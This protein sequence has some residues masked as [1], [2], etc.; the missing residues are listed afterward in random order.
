M[1]NISFLLAT[2]NCSI[3]N[4][5][6]HFSNQDLVNLFYKKDNFSNLEKYAIKVIKTEALAIEID[7]FILENNIPPSIVNNILEKKF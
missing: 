1:P 6:N 5:A 2:V 7:W 3:G 4:K